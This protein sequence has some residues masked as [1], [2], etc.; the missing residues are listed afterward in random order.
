MPHIN[1]VQGTDHSL[2]SLLVL[3]NKAEKSLLDKRE[4]A[5]VNYFENNES[6]LDDNILF[7]NE[8]SHA[9]N[10]ILKKQNKLSH[11]FLETVYDFNVRGAR[12]VEKTDEE[13]FDGNYLLKIRA[14][15]H[16]H[17]AYAAMLNNIMFQRSISKPL[18]D[19]VIWAENWYEHNRTAAELTAEIY[20]SYSAQAYI[21]SGNA[22]EKM[23]FILRNNEWGVKALYCYNKFINFYNDLENS[24]ISNWYRKYEDV[25]TRMTK[26]NSIISNPNGSK[27]FRLVRF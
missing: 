23:C 4:R 11:K 8:L 25:Q 3:S 7:L 24:D 16:T 10:R 27:R 1:S 12:F 13:G 9:V 14:V 6:F 15:M 17:A 22:S 5:V 20:P 26:L 2:E 19:R 21:L 18:V